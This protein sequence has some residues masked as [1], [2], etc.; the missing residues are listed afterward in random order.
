VT[1]TALARLPADLRVHTTLESAGKIDKYGRLNGDLIFVGRGDP[2]LSNRPLPFDPKASR[3]EPPLMA[4]E[5]LANQLAARGI[6]VIDGDVVG[7]DSFY[8]NE[9]YG[10]HWGWDDLTWSWGAPVSALTLNDNV[11]SVTI[12]PGEVV[13]DRPFI[14]ME[15][16]YLS[17][18]IQNDLYTTASGRERHIHIERLPGRSVLHFWGAV[19]LDAKPEQELLAVE[20]PARLAAEALRDA[21][22]TR[23][24]RVY[25]DVRVHH[26]EVWELGPKIGASFLERPNRTVLAEI[27]SH[28]FREDLKVIAKVSQNLHA[29][30]LL[31]LL[32]A[33]L[34]EEGSV[35]AGLQVEKEFLKE[36]GVE[37]SEYLLNDGSGMDSQNL[38]AP[39]AMVQLLKYVWSQPYR[40]V[41]IELLPV[42]GVD[43]TIASRF[44]GTPLAERVFAKTGTLT[45]VNALSG[46]ATSPEAE[47]FVFSMFVN[48]HS[49]ESK[50]ATTTLDKILETI[51]T[52]REP[53]PRKSGKK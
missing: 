25:G 44:K 35:R 52:Y 31:R 27:V 3:P 1:T 8:V 28:P 20:E 43:G 40:D 6:R 46:Y 50:I 23:G 2:N 17:L 47:H 48:N 18:R 51:L 21:L 34:K 41:F 36:A 22:L 45:H 19:P 13:G 49:Q 42:A 39:H 5:T 10:D 53:T 29:E 32:G 26:R 33:Q 7:D 4:V 14:A 24:I 38:V 9:P 15:P 11:F 12:F 30:M 37:E 16:F